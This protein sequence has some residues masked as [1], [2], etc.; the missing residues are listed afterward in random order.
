MEETICFSSMVTPGN[1]I[2][3]EPVA[4]M[5]FLASSVCSPPLPVISDLAAAQEAPGALHIG[6]LVLLEQEL[7]A[8][9]EI[10]HHLVLARQHRRQI[11][12]HIADL[13]AVRPQMLRRFLVEVRGLQQRLRGNAADI[14]AGAA[15][16]PRFSTQAVFSP[17]CAARI[18][19]TY[20]PGPPPM[21]TTSKFSL[22]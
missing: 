18:A 1:G 19:A 21:T 7:D 5:M 14:E 8:L 3:S 22:P 10:A 12:H 16:A 4:M 9:G 6:N 20:P 17:S 13:D 2:T 11:E 15:E